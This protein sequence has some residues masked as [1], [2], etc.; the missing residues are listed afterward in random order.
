MVATL[1]DK[2]LGSAEN[3]LAILEKQQHEHKRRLD[4]SVTTD[5]ESGDKDGDGASPSSVFERLLALQTTT[6]SL[7]L[8]QD[9]L[10]FLE[11]V[12]KEFSGDRDDGIN[13]NFEALSVQAQL[14][15]ELAHQ[16]VLK[17][18]DSLLDLCPAL[19]EEGYLPL[20]DYLRE[21]L[22]TL[23]REKLQS[24]RYP[25]AKGCEELLRGENGTDYLGTVCQHLIRLEST[26]R[27]VLQAVEG[28]AVE[29]D[30][31]S[32]LLELFHP[33]LDRVYFH[34][35]NTGDG[36]PGDPNNTANNESRITAKRLERLPEW[37]LNYIKSNFL[38]DDGPYQVVRSVMGPSSASPFCQ[39][40]IR[41]IQ[42][43]LVDQRN[44]FDDP[45]IS[46][47]QS[48]PQFLYHA[49]EQ[50]MEF[51]TT[52]MELLADTSGTSDTVTF[53]SKEQ[54]SFSAPKFTG[55]MDA[56]VASNE[57]LFDWWIR[58]ERESVSSTLFPDDDSASDNVP[59][60]PLASYISP[61]AELFCSLIRSV[62][63]KA[64]TLTDPKIY[65]RE[66]AV[67]LC[68][69]FVD[70]LH[71]TSV[72]LRN[73]LVQG[74][75]RPQPPQNQS[76]SSYTR[77]MVSE[78]QRLVSNIN[79]WIEIINGAQLAS[80][81]LLS[82]E[83]A[84][85]SQSDHDLGR[86]GRSLERL[87]EVMMDE[88]A[89]AFV[90]TTLMEHAKFANYL[91]LAAH[92]LASPDHVNEDMTGD[93]NLTAELSD[94][95]AVLQYFQETCDSI[96]QPSHFL[97][98]EHGDEEQKLA[99]CA[100]L[101][102]RARVADR[103]VEKFL[104]VALDTT[105]VTPDIWL[106]GAAVFAR[107]VNIILGAYCDIPAVDRLLEVTKFMTMDYDSFQGL[108]AAIGGL[109]GSDAYLDIEELNT[110]A[111]LRDEASSM[112]KAKNV[113]CPLKYAVSILNRR[114]G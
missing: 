58:R 102:M 80:Q 78:K 5:S 106:E 65:L 34:F 63:L 31:N 37:L 32:V 92:L 75:R 64:S 23:L 38:Q 25:T 42:W 7:A 60:T 13:D 97:G 29:S 46:G 87:V 45:A 48:N 28:V 112:L 30:E 94:T 22:V 70:A 16:V 43:V 11:S 44:F 69:Q 114:R 95:K 59:K 24:T 21:Y 66:V 50:F 49:V 47:P 79:E 83:R 12:P 61:R 96:L 91:M 36:D 15:D 77:I 98:E 103:L 89:M 52:L 33:L 17:H 26:H 86:F 35:I 101:G 19:Y 88:F 113:N 27:Q 40:L 107:D 67:P 109:T 74:N 53:Q 111:T 41:L 68:S 85:S 10:L 18:A 62:Q 39:E 8:A 99:S 100:P 6:D 54:T 2:E 84:A 71:E 14:C 4:G 20:F 108:F 73:P 110:D 104:D 82:N 76:S 90:E 57:E 56:L 55:L 9:F 72:N 93:D 105:N 3:S 51:D 81:I 1:L